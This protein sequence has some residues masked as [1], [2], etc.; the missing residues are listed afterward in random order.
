[1]KKHSGQFRRLTA[2][3]LA[4]CMLAALTA[5]IFAADIVDSGYCGGEGDGTNLTW[6]LDSA[7]TLTISGHGM[8]ENYIYDEFALPRWEKEPPW[9][10][11]RYTYDRFIFGEGVTSIGDYAF[12]GLKRLKENM[13]FPSSL[14]S[15]GAHAFDNCQGLTGDLY[16]PDNVTYIGE[17]AFYNCTGLNGNL[18]IPES[19]MSIGCSAFQS[20]EQLTGTLSIPATVTYIGAGAFSQCKSLTGDLNVPEGITDIAEETFQGC[21]GLTG[22]VNI[23][24]SVTKIGDGAFA[25]CG[26]TGTLQLPQGL[27]SIGAN[28]FFFNNGLTGNLN[29]PKS[30]KS[31]GYGAF[32]LC[33]G[34]TGDLIIP[35]DITKIEDHTFG[36][37]SGFDGELVLPEQLT[38]I[39]AYAFEKCN[40]LT[41]NLVLPDKV[42]EVGDHAFWN[43]TGF[44]GELKIPSG[45][46]DI[47][48]S[49]FEFC[50]GLSG[51]LTLSDEL[52]SIGEYAF[53]MCS[54]LVGELIVPKRVAE[55]SSMAFFGCSIANAFFLGDA[56]T[57]QESGIGYGSF[58]RDITLH[59]IDGSTGWIDSDAYDAVTSTWNG[60]KLETWVPSA[61]EG[62]YSIEYLPLGDIVV[63]GAGY[64]Y[65]RFRLLDSL[66]APVAG[67]N[68]E[69]QFLMDDGSSTSGGSVTDGNGVF[70]VV[71][72]RLTASDATVQT[73]MLSMSVTDAKKISGNVH[74]LPVRVKKFSYSQ[75]ATIYSGIELGASIGIGAGGELGAASAKAKLIDLTESLGL[76]GK[77]KIKETYEDGSRSVKASYQ[78]SYSK[79]MKLDT[80][81]QADALGLDYKLISVSG[82]VGSAVK[83][84]R[85]VQIENYDPTNLEQQQKLGYFLIHGMLQSVNQSMLL[86]ELFAELNG[87]NDATVLTG[88]T[89]ISLS[90]DAS[91]NC[92]DGDGGESSL[93]SVGGGTAVSHE[94]ELDLLKQTNGFTTKIEADMH[95]KSALLP[96]INSPLG[97]F[98]VDSIISYAVSAERKNDVLS[99]I[100]FTYDSAEKS[101]LGFAKEAVGESQTYTISGDEAIRLQ[102]E[103]QNLAKFTTGKTGLLG[104]VKLE[105]AIRTILDGK[106]DAA[107]SVKKKETS[108]IDIKIP[109]GIKI[110]IG[111]KLKLS[112]GAIRSFSYETETGCR[113]DGVYYTL[114]QDEVPRDEIDAQKKGALNLVAEPI[115]AICSIINEKISST[116]S[117]IKKG[118][119]EQYISVKG[120]VDSWVAQVS[121]VK[122]AQ[123]GAQAESFAIMSLTDAAE[124]VSNA[125]I[126]I[127]LGEPYSLT[128]YT[129]KEMQ[130]EVPNETLAQ[131]PVELTLRYTDDMLAAANAGA[132]ANVYIY[133]FDTERN[134]YICQPQS[135]Q[136]KTAKSVTVSVVK[137]G[138]YILATDNAAPL[139]TDFATTDQTATPTISALV[140]DL[141]G[142]QKF[143]FWLDEQEPLV[144]EA[145]LADHYNET[146]GEFLCKITVPLSAGEHTAYFQAS[147][148]LGNANAVPYT[149]TFTVDNT[150]PVI[151]AIQ[152][153]KQTV[154][155]AAELSISARIQ[156][157]NAVSS[158]WLQISEEDGQSWTVP[159]TEAD[160]VWTAQIQGVFGEQT[161]AVT[162][163]ALD[164]AGNRA[165]SE[166]LTI[167][168]N[169]PREASGI[170]MQFRSVSGGSEADAAILI[171]NKTQSA[172]SGWLLC[173]AYDR[174]GRQIAA[175]GQYIGLK[176][177]G[178]STLTLHLA[179]GTGEIAA[180]KAFLLD[181]STGYR[182][183]CGSAVYI[184]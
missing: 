37:C 112:A 14:T 172:M 142:I 135:R 119:H 9:H 65:A 27:T 100:S 103:N 24:N 126:A 48:A 66:G 108:S 98:G 40:G 115:Q 57:V 90:A 45:V 87:Y 145:N 4:L 46:S 82:E 120:T 70:L 99:K 33:S 114:S 1:M 12:F 69:L 101:S 96:L 36:S 29:I 123:T 72:P 30:V 55:I 157:D 43:C 165:D 138:E 141:S 184:K 111:G 85:G 42:T 179:C 71:T 15:V 7:G 64:G 68:V 121:S 133:Y 156:D 78:Q 117:E 154:L 128:V 41:G 77:T 51:N 35:K 67:K 89:E 18:H 173:A 113:K 50:S 158:A 73:I 130:E 122:K 32:Q 49:A 17:Y 11:S 109:I 132:D 168:T 47:G 169:I 28:A 150:P 129:D 167:R 160:A 91:A 174:N 124:P 177:Q 151:S 163:C 5:E 159:M 164:S 155:S 53:F 182:P 3:A 162:V 19:L 116:W 74:A 178:Q 88:E 58:P 131:K 76:G 95:I 143:K 44:T 102:Q 104:I 52:I 110:F 31:I 23:P 166:T 153:P 144:T 148:T 134:I 139:I 8:M 97:M 83:Y 25:S 39:G 38:R 59:Y 125:A 175:N 170:R 107:L 54:G 149:F 183:L 34:F 6:T 140:S 147:D 171:E 127:T 60:Y 181:P 20:C 56:P 22:K 161:L 180:V 26:F 176:A 106:Y 80:G 75:E 146:T 2:L 21:R 84:E 105:D 94:T 152:Y 79:G 10:K 16:I 62:V 86:Y 63:N 118:L 13:R 93:F 61:E 137:N 92:S 136:D 81:I